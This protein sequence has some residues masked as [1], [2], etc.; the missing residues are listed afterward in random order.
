M[1]LTNK[2][3]QVVYYNLVMKH[4]RERYMVTAASGQIL[5][6]RDGQKLKSRTFAQ[7]YHAEQWLKR[8]GYTEGY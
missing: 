6:G 8:N 1:R 4:G 2:D 7:C 3:G 5:R